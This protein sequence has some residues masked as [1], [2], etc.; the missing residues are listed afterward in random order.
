MEARELQFHPY[1][2]IF[3]LMEGEP[4]D[5]LVA[6][7][8]AHGLREV[9]LL[10]DDGRIIDGRNRYRA[11]IATGVEPAFRTYEGGG[12]VLI[13][14]IW[15]KNGARRHLNESQRA[16]AAAKLACLRIGQKGEKG[17]RTSI[18]VAAERLNVSPASIDRAKRVIAHGSKPLQRAVERGEVAVSSAAAIADLPKAKQRKLVERGPEAIAQAA[19]PL[20]PTPA[21]RL[22]K[23]WDEA[24][25]GARAALHVRVGVSPGGFVGLKL[26]WL[27]CTLAEKRRFYGE[28]II[29]GRTA[30]ECGQPSGSGVLA[31]NHG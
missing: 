7:I 20:P 11:C 30:L 16:M 18:D 8:K 15:D 9:I 29:P 26:A 3:P 10:A 19:R 25:E 22:Q 4:F 24:P 31:E 1:A 2:D 17:Q 13:D 27:D 14:L 12:E 28:V 21:E 5:D 6:S 23:A